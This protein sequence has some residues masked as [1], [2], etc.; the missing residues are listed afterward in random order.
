MP[1]SLTNAPA[2]FCGLMNDV[3]YDFLDKFVIVYLDDI[4]VYS[5][6]L[7]DHIDQRVVFRKVKEYELYIKQEKCELCRE[8]I[9]FLGHVLNNGWIQMDCRKV[10]AILDWLAP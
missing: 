8:Q 4:I 1:F 6:S 9:T 5:K 2:T 7:K 3:L 10:E